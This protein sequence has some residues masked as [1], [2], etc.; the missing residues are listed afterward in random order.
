MMRARINNYFLS[1]VMSLMLL[2]IMTACDTQE[3]LISEIEF[4]IAKE[5]KLDNAIVNGVEQTNEIIQVDRPSHNL[6]FYRL[7]LEE[8]FTFERTGIDNVS[9]KGTWSLTA[10]LSQVHLS[11][12]DGTEEHYLLLDLEVRR[13]EMRVLQDPSKLGELD[14][15]YILKPVKGR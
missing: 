10:G 2:T 5:W 7:K 15:R 4:F 11:F 14:I 3:I 1:L 12:E 8:D 9:L 13:L 6:G